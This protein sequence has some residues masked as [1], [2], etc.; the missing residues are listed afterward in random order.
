M[1]AGNADAV[2]Y[3]DVTGTLREPI[4]ELSYETKSGLQVGLSQ[5]EITRV[6]ALDVTWDDYNDLSSGELATKGSSD[7]VRH[8]AEA[9]VARA[10]RREMGVDVFNF[11][12]NVFTGEAEDPYAEFTVGQHL[13]RDLFISYTGK[14]H[15]YGSGATGSPV[16][17]HAAEADYELRRDFYLVGSTYEDEGSQRYGLGLRF[18]HK[19]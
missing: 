18:I 16:L 1:R 17:E 4:L 11:D 15:E 12:A 8:Y 7:Y 19:Y 3:I 13:T 5:E 9:E 6:L 10:V 2:V 14:Y